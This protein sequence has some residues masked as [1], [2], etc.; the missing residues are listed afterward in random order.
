[1]HGFLY[2]VFYSEDFLREI[3]FFEKKFPLKA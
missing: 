1:L 2:L 3:F